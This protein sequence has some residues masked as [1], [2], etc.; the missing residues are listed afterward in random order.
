MSLTSASKCVCVKY[1]MSAPAVRRTLQMLCAAF[2]HHTFTLT[3]VQSAMRHK[4]HTAWA[5]LLQKLGTYTHTHSHTHSHTHTRTHTHKQTHIHTHTH[6]HSHIHTHMHAVCHVAQGP[7]RL[8]LAAAQVRHTHTHSYTHTLTHTHS[9]TLTRVQSA[10]W[11]KGHTAWAL[12]LHKM[13]QLADPPQPP[14]PPPKPKKTKGKPKG[15]IND[16]SEDQIPAPPSSTASSG[17]SNA[18][19]SDEL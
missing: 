3:R 19:N 11:H 17:K 6:A 7:H 14:S 15:V 1:W 2:V 4:G 9:H 13:G 5:L 16:E 8:G 12:L 10:M 18:H